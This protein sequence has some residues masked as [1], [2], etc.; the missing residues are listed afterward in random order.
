M[1]PI[2]GSWVKLHGQ[3]STDKSEVK[4]VCKGIIP[5]KCRN[6]PNDFSHALLGLK[7]N[8]CLSVLEFTTLCPPSLLT[9]SDISCTPLE[10]VHL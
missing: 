6:K 1:I 9:G 5:V 4:L 3:Y 7:L 10:D 2:N 8:K